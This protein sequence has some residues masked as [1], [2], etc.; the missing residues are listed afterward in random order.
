MNQY[1]MVIVLLKWNQ[2]ENIFAVA[3]PLYWLTATMMLLLTNG[4]LTPMTT[5]SKK[6][7]NHK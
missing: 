5:Q 7:Q 6:Y 1:K 4:I 2:A 3:E